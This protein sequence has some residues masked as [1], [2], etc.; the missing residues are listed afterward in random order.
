MAV[1]M[2]VDTF[3]E[4]STWQSRMK[5]ALVSA[6]EATQLLIHILGAHLRSLASS[7]RSL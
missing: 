2:E 4:L 3:L 5:F 7:P 6:I 1:S